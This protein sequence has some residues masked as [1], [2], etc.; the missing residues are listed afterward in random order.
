MKKRLDVSPRSFVRACLRKMWLRSREHQA[1]LKR[2]HYTCERCGAKQ[3]RAKGREVYVE[4]HHRKGIP[5][6]DAVIDAIFE[7]ILCSAEDLEVL[8]KDCHKAESAGAEVVS[9]QCMYPKTD[10]IHRKN[11]KCYA[12]RGCICPATGAIYGV[13]GSSATVSEKNVTTSE[14]RANTSRG[15]G[16]DG[17]G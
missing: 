5:N 16:D 1:A 7:Y 3:S 17:R 12:F 13:W 15:G 8:C 10:C 14:A 6:W 9:G 11:K 2:E 4:V